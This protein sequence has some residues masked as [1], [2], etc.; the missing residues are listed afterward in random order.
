MSFEGLKDTIL[1]HSVPLPRF[2]IA[3]AVD[4]ELPYLVDILLLR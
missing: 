3:G 2:T 1:V 4:F